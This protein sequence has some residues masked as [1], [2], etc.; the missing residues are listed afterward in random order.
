[1]SLPDRNIAWPIYRDIARYQH[2]VR[3][4]V[5]MIN[6]ITSISTQKTAFMTKT[7]CM[8]KTAFMTKTAFTTKTALMTKTS[9][10]TKTALMTKTAFMTK[11]SF[12][13]KSKG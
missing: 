2:K 10:T 3:S 7:T 6:S 8:I 9:F 11:T 12:V 13:T 1:M 5:F 4:R